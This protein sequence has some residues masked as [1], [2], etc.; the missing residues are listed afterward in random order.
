MR[1][2]VFATQKGGCGKRTL[3]ACLVVVG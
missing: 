3:A 2:I 1:T